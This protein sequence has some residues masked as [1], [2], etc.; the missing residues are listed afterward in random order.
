HLVPATDRRDRQRG[1]PRD[2]DDLTPT[3]HE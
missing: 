1:K 2:G 3:I